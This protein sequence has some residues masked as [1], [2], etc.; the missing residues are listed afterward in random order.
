MQS[1]WRQGGVPAAAP[2]PHTGGAGAGN[3]SGGSGGP[4]ESLQALRDRAEAVKLQ[5][6]IKAGELSIAKAEYEVAELA[7]KTAEAESAKRKLEQN[8]FMSPQ[9]RSPTRSPGVSPFAAQ[10][11][12][13]QSPALTDALA[14]MKAAVPSFAKE[15][16]KPAKEASV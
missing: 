7:R 14:Q 15:A 3:V 8:S 2:P 9:K 12:H 11:S 5:Q 4:S 16:D 10:S 6:E 1:A 13:E